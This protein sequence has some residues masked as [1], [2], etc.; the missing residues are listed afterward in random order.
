MLVRDQM[1]TPAVTVRSDEDYKVAL[2]LM[3][4]YALHHL[5]VVDAAG[6][7]VGMAAERDLVLA[8]TRFLQSGVEVGEIMHRGA[9]TAKPDTS[10]TAA[11]NLML[12]HRIGGLPVIDAEEHIVGLI[13][14]T[15]I[16]KVF[17]EMA[18][19]QTDRQL[20]LAV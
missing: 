1:S 18:D 17:V 7:L 14:E 4:D 15:D 9:I 2:R 16:F 3:Q 6:Q 10:L 13:T 19:E 8:A 20:P 12:R 11:A 5:P